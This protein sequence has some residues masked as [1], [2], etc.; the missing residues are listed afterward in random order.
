MRSDE[1]SALV[2][3]SA[4]PRDGRDLAGHLVLLPDESAGRWAM[5]RTL[6][7]RGAGFPAAEVLRL[8][9]A[10]CAAAADRLAASEDD[11]E[12]LRQRALAAL[13][14]ELE[15]SGKDGLDRI[16]K[17][18]HRVKKGRPSPGVGLA[19]G[20]AAA[21]DAWNAA[22]ER[23]EG[24]RREYQAA[25]AAG[26]ARL[27]RALH[28]TA[29]DQRFREAIGWQN[30]H[31]ARTGLAAFLRWEQGKG[32][33]TARDRG[34]AQMLAS[35]LQR[36]CTKNDTIGFFGPVG[37]GRV[38]EGAEAIAVRPGRELLAARQVYFEGWAIDAVAGRLAEDPAMRPWLAPRRSPF[39]RREADGYSLPGGQRIQLGPL[40]GALMEACDGTRPARAL[41][42]ELGP[43]LTAAN[44]ALLW[45][46]LADLHA[47][48]LLCWA[49]QIPLGVSPERT[50][51]ELILAVEEKPL[52]DRALAVLDELERG[53]D[54]VA[55]AAGR[56]DELERALDEL[57]AA[58][59]RATDLPATRDSGKTYA[60]RT[61][62]Y[63]D[64]RRDLDLELGAPFLAALAPALSLVLASARWFTH[65]VAM[66]HREV[67]AGVH[68]E[69]S[70]ALGS[71]QVDLL[72]FVR[73]ALPRLL[74]E[75]AGRELQGELNARWE[76]VLAIPPGERR[77]AYRSADLLPLVQREFAA[78]RPGWQQARYHSP[79]MLIAA[80]SVEAIRR[81]D[82]Q[83]VL[84]ETHLGI[85]SIDRWLFVAQ[86]PDPESLRAAIAADLP[87]PCLIPVLP[88]TWREE[89]AAA[90]FG[91]RVPGLN[92]RLTVALSSAKD[93]HLDFTLDPPGVPAAQVLS[94]GEL[95]V[96]PSE[97]GL[98]VG[99]RAGGVRFDVVDFFQIVMMML[100]H[101]AFRVR[102]AG[103]Y[104]PR[105]TID[106]VVVTRE[107]WIVPATE[108]AGEPTAASRFAAVRRWAG[109][110]GLPR[111]L[112]AKMP[113]EW[114]PFY[115]DLDSPVLVEI[116][117][118]AARKAAKIS[119]A[120]TI[121]LSEMLPGHDQ[122]WLP[123]AEGNRY[124]CELRT[125]A[126]DLG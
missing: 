77:V 80:A 28:E 11:A 78:P 59:T 42:R 101:D 16:V 96:E 63:E 4:P 38:G 67:F 40:S 14:G 118:K 108:L 117:A 5:W 74:Y 92:G 103:A 30:R 64:C 93:F 82:Y 26:E 23:R 99:P 72:S 27:H 29:A 41:M 8:A 75:G 81:G 85:N 106:R 68:A 115:V 36:Y 119:A 39:L 90:T 86:H 12:G 32:G 10:G 83:I 124:T 1:A 46:L 13:R 56:V 76:R 65:F 31:A 122:L 47:K 2:I 95:I 104:T 70:G 37:W 79:D 126:V 43:A 105:V 9:D 97:G 50:L 33:G 35:Y 21:L 69:L 53:R 58:F 71:P 57:E 55:R 25:F 113:Y 88:K 34:H 87:K 116:L 6:C 17:A 125:V 19:V 3:E 51:R 61:L 89:E 15:G 62:V 120:A 109:E 112:F 110:R 121:T 84:G 20:T 44:E 7:V 123:D 18:I 24:E 102:P 100:A 45:G 107:S 111:F 49:F 91:L 22:A 98:A 52:R 60:G 73:A 48:G 94:I 54:A 114:K 66:G